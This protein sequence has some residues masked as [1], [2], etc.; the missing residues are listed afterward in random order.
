M[1]GRDPARTRAR[2]IDLG[3][4]LWVIACVALGVRL[5]HEVQGL[6]GL[7]VTV[8][9]VGGQLEGLGGDLAGLDIPLVGDQLDGIG[10]QA[11]ASG[12]QARQQAVVA[13]DS[14][15]SLA[16]LLAVAVVVLALVP[17][18]LVYVP[19]RVRSWREQT[20]ARELE[21]R[22]KED[23]ELRR[24][25][26]QRAILTMPAH[27]LAARPGRPWAAPPAPGRT[28]ATP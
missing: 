21:D 24:L 1:A 10:E 7:T 26:A 5:H 25:L 4:V 11:R 27:E 18:L 9:R 8:D 14:V 23:P 12:A 13:R 16:W 6:T 20:A 3:V 2:W 22:A 19:L 15:K 28:R 17:V